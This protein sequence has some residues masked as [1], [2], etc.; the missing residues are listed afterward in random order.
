[1]KIEIS[2]FFLNSLNE[3]VLKELGNIWKVETT[4]SLRTLFSMN[5]M[6]AI[7]APTYAKCN[8]KLNKNLLISNLVIDA[9]IFC[10]HYLFSR[11]SW[12]FETG[13]KDR[14]LTL[15]IFFLKSTPRYRTYELEWVM[16]GITPNPL[17]QRSTHATHDGLFNRNLDYQI[18]FSISSTV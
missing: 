8:K 9:W 12:R 5:N 14:K 10:F 2:C 17:N 1:M 16:H 18:D 3:A 7:H 6:D 4:H 11:I 15:G 13:K